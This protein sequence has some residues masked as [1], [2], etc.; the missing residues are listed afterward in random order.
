MTLRGII[1]IIAEIILVIF[2]LGTEFNK[3][4]LVAAC[5]GGV[6]LYSFLSLLFATLTLN[7]KSNIDKKTVFRSETVKYTLSLY[8]VALLPVSSY[9]FIKFTERNLLK[10]NGQRHSFMLLP[11]FSVRRNF[12]FEFSCDH[13]GEWEMGVKKMRLEDLFGLFSFPLVRSRKSDFSI[14]VSVMP[15]IHDLSMNKQRDSVGGTGITSV[16]CS[17]EGELLGDSRLYREGDS[18][19][20]INWKQ[21]ARAKKLY[22]RMYEVTQGPVAVIIVDTNVLGDGIDGIIDITCESALSLSE[23]FMYDG[24]IVSV[25]TVRGQEGDGV[26]VYNLE[27][28]ADILMLRDVF[29]DMP[30]G[31]LK[32]ELGLS[33]LQNEQVIGADR[34]YLITSNP[35]DDLVNA[36]ESI[37][38]NGKVACCIVPAARNVEINPLFSNKISDITRV[39]IASAD[40]IVEK[41]GAAL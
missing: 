30:F 9:F 6:I 8:G 35:S 27:N 3:I 5:V 28:Y 18:L 12:T 40:Q 26:T 17:E 23:Y 7:V 1:V 10:K 14:K 15:N 36:C 20:R 41:V 33:V 4:M 19:K 24:N 21:S 32:D 37:N 39:D 13:I 38:K 16:L 2:A 11:S 34:I 22:S 31:K 25:I 29:L